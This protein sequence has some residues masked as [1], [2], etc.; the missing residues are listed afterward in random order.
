MCVCVHREYNTFLCRMRWIGYVKRICESKTLHNVCVCVCVCVCVWSMRVSGKGIVTHE[1]ES[2]LIFVHTCKYNSHLVSV[3]RC[4]PSD[5]S[6]CSFLDVEQCR[7]LCWHGKLQCVCVCVFVCVCMSECMCE[8]AEGIVIQ[9]KE[10]R[11]PFVHTF[12]SNSHLV[13]VRRCLQA[14]C[15]FFSYIDVKQCRILC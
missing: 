13:P 4:R 9:E 5:G 6:I 11:L 15:T 10:F 2:R 3:H 8:C 14:V 7:I 12:V 1:K